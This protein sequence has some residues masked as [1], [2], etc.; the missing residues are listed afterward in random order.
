MSRS[1]HRFRPA[2]GYITSQASSNHMTGPKGLTSI[3]IRHILSRSRIVHQIFKTRLSTIH[4]IFRSSFKSRLKLISAW[5]RSR[6]CIINRR[7]FSRSK[8]TRTSHM[9]HIF[10]L[11]ISRSRAF[12]SSCK[13]RPMSISNRHPRFYLCKFRLMNRIS[14]W[15]RNF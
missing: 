9:S 12:F 13:I 14:S 7:S 3:N 2:S 1:R 4:P 10:R 15:T 11:V 8:R 5:T 6:I